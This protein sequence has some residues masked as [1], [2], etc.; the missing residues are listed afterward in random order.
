MQLHYSKCPFKNFNGC[1]LVCILFRHNIEC[2]GLHIV[3]NGFKRLHPVNT[4]VRGEHNL[5]F[6]WGRFKHI[7]DSQF[8]EIVTT[9]KKIMSF[10]DHGVVVFLFVRSPN[11]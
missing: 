8:L 9:S 2:S 3:R 5:Y 7:G 10:Y 1:I 6:L 4:V 11:E